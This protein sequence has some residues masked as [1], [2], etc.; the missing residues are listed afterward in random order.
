MIKKTYFCNTG[1]EQITKTAKQS[2][3]AGRV[4]VPSAW[5]GCEVA[6]IRLSEKRVDDEKV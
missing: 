3:H 6:I 4:Y 1:Y 5:V 2:G